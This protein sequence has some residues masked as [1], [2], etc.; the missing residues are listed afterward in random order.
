MLLKD[1]YIT[2]V[3]QAMDLFDVGEGYGSIHKALAR[4]TCPV[5]IIGVQTDILFPI[6]QQRFLAR[7]LQEAGQYTF[8]AIS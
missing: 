3:Q 8:H 4:V 7:S 6:H 1:E 5:M 2:F